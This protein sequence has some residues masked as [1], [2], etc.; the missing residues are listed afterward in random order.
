MSAPQYVQF[1]MD[2]FHIRH[3][4]SLPW[5]GVSRVMLFDLELY[6]EC[7]SAVNLLQNYWNISHLVAS[8]PQHVQLWMASFHIFLNVVLASAG[9][10]QMGAL[11]DLSCYRY[12]AATRV[13]DTLMTD[14]RISW[15]CH[16][17]ETYSALLALCAG[18]S[19]VIGELPSQRPVTRS[20]VVFFHLCL[21]KRLS[22]Q[23]WGW[24]VE[25]PLCPLWR[26]RYVTQL[27]ILQIE[28]IDEN[29]CGL[30][31]CLHGNHLFW[32]SNMS[33]A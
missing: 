6:L 8:T 23:S 12:A 32:I 4:W 17:I 2:S 22:K 14:N 26:H 7:R 18:I 28:Q 31:Y 29:S 33:T 11:L 13:T 3:I 1:W 10:S 19:T 16:E 24:W 21:N 25:T 30:T 15:W 27:L 9:Y 5:E 20:F